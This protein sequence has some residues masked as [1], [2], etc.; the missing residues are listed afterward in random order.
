MR[1]MQVL[2]LACASLLVCA[3]ALVG[4]GGSSEP[5]TGSSGDS[6]PADTTEP[7][8][9]E[10]D[11]QEDGSEVETTMADYMSEHYASFD[12]FDEGIKSGENIPKSLH[13]SVAEDVDGYVHDKDEIVDLWKK[14]C[15]IKVDYENPE[16]GLS[17]SDGDIVFSFD[18]GTEI[19]P[20]EFITSDYATFTG[21][22]LFPVVN[23]RDVRELVERVSKLVE[24]TMP[25]VGEEV[26]K[27]GI[28]YLWDA[29][30]DGDLEHMWL[31]F[32]DNGDE[33]ASGY[34]IRLYD[35]KL[36]TTAYLD[37]AYEIQSVVLE[38]DADG[39][40]VV[41]SYDSSQC[42]LRLVGDELVVE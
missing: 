39:Y 1:N 32:N 29:D 20:F 15:A 23:P 40:Y 42:T 22:S 34:E 31:T 24:D 37:N 11:T 19:M 9:T 38:E 13:V 3:L 18:S 8:D 36:D 10:S 4:C 7:T 12:A 17:I 35:D 14:L 28:A 41:V 16:V 5:A 27:E 33:A 30:G 26:P 2:A 6:K 25:V 21:T